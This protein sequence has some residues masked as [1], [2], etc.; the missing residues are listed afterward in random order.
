VYDSVRTPTGFCHVWQLPPGFGNFPEDA[1]YQRCALD[2]RPTL[3][4]APFPPAPRYDVSANSSFLI[5]INADGTVDQERTRGYSRSADTVFYREA[6]E[7]IR[8]WR[9]DPG[10]R[11]G[12]PVRSAYEI[13]FTTDDRVDTLPARIEWQYREGTDVDTVRGTWV[14]EAP[15]PPFGQEQSDSI[16]AALLRHLVRMQVLIPTQG[17]RYCFVLPG[18]DSLAH[19]RRLELTARTVP[20]LART[21]MPYGCERTPGTIRVM[22]PRVYQTENGRAVIS[23]SGDFL[24]NWP[25]GFAGKSWRAW[26]GRCVLELRA[27]GVGV[28]TP[29]CEVTPAFSADEPFTERENAWPV[30]ADYHDGDSVRVTVFAT[31]TDAVGID[32]LRTVVRDLR[33][34]DAYSI[35]DPNLPCGGW[36]AYSSERGS[37]IVLG[38]P[39]SN[40]LNITAVSN[41]V[42]PVPRNSTM[43]CGAQE[44]RTDAFT[45]FLLGDLGDRPTRPITLCFSRCARTYVLD[46]AR[47]TVAERS[48]IV[49]RTSDLRAE[50][51]TG[52]A[53]S[54]RLVLEPAPSSVLPLVVFRSGNQPPTLAW[55]AKR[56]GP[57]V[58]DYTVRSESEP[59]DEIHVYLIVT[60]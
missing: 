5:V 48:H 34:L 13:Q 22:L 55:I 35:R 33:H 27:V 51:R 58:W 10:I 11:A 54:F 7:T 44:P 30:S 4:P 57:N 12:T 6:L 29:E 47:H 40:S 49:F 3:R 38:D 20:A 56:A 14:R 15:L 26:K 21:L 8:R 53:L 31:T 18:E 16:H 39:T 41:R 36:A 43:R 60:R 17:R 1:S 19:T 9:F 28:G 42:P 59:D 45:A 2:R 32:T 46:P 37:Y 52:A 25:R 50:T 23:P 24:A